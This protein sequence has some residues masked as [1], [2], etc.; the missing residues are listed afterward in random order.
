M[1]LFFALLFPPSTLDLI[2][3]IQSRVNGLCLD[4]RF[5][6]REN[7]HLT[8]HFLGNIAPSRRSTLR[9]IL[10]TTTAE[11]SPIPLT[12]DRLGSF[13]ERRQTKLIYLTARTS[14]PLSALEQSLRRSLLSYGF[15]L[16]NRS[17]LPHVTLA[18]HCHVIPDQDPLTLRFPAISACVKTVA[19]MLIRI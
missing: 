4:G 14:P 8:L 11:A 3:D 12:F 1:R 6:H 9:H 13:N 7:L 10:T 19:L 18:R 17:F 15:S 16:E 5:T 2:M